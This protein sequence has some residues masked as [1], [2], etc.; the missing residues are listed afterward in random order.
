MRLWF[1]LTAAMAAVV[2]QLTSDETARLENDPPVTHKVTFGMLKNGDP[3][4][5]LVLALFGETVPK[6]AE[7]FVGLLL[8]LK[9]FGYKGTKFHRIIKDFMVQGGN[10]DES[11]GG[12]S[13]YPERLFADE[14]FQIKHNKKGRLLMANSGPNRNGAQFF[15]TTKED[16]SW[17]DG[18]HVVF[19][20][21]VN[22]FDVLAEMNEQDLSPD[23]T[24]TIDSTNVVVLVEEGRPEKL[25]D[26]AEDKT[27][28]GTNG[29]SS[30]GSTSEQATYTVVDDSTSPAYWLFFAVPLLAAVVL[31]ARQ[32]RLRKTIT[33]FKESPRLSSGFS[34]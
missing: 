16:C 27:S 9:G 29:G 30:E 15:I 26:E 7:N 17:L 23:I 32:L 14:N 18:K 12:Y 5:N 19:G 31:C 8:L 1:L 6:T 10:F 11:T 4:G 3:R 33:T 25:V 24:W 28:E 13:I 2:P 21:L 34:S 22:G 20:Q